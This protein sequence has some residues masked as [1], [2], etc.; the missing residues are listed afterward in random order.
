ME[1]IGD[2]EVVEWGALPPTLRIESGIE[3]EPVPVGRRRSSRTGTLL[4]SSASGLMCTE[5]GGSGDSDDVSE[6]NVSV[7]ATKSVPSCSTH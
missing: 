3:P 5:E 1:D 7:A 2:D 6:T 4:D